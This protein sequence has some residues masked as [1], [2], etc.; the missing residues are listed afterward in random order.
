MA[1]LL[2][3]V[4][5]SPTCPHCPAAVKATKEL[6][7]KYNELKSDV[8]WK[9]VSTGTPSGSSKA[10]SYGISSVPT[11]IMTNLKT[12]ERFGIVGVPGDKKYLNMIYKGIGKSS[13]KE[14]NSQENNNKM[15]ENTYNSKNL[16]D[17]FANLFK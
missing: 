8:T 14:K 17:K 5:T 13:E 10:R 1:T 12:N 3:E 7:E 6:F 11:I 2:I 15:S 16:I 4:F 9:E